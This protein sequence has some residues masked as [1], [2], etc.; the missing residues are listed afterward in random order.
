[1]DFTNDEKKLIDKESSEMVARAPRI[2]VKTFKFQGH[3][4][5]MYWGFDLLDFHDIKTVSQNRGYKYIMILLDFYS[6]YVFSVP[7]KSKD[8]P[9]IIKA[10]DNVF[11]N[12]V[13]SEF[14]TPR[15]PTFLCS[16]EESAIMSGDFKSF[17]KSMEFSVYN[18]YGK[19]GVAPV[20]S[21]IRTFKEKLSFFW[22]RQRR[23]WIDH[24][25]E[26]VSNYNL[27]KHSALITKDGEKVSPHEVYIDGVPLKKEA[28][29]Y[30]EN[31]KTKYDLDIGDRVRFRV[32]KD[33]S[34]VKKKSLLPN[35]SI[36]VY[37][38]TDIIKTSKNQGRN[39]RPN[40]GY[41]IKS[42]SENYKLVD[43]FD[44]TFGQELRNANKRLFYRNELKKSRLDDN[45]ISKLSN[46]SKRL[47]RNINNPH[48]I[49]DPL[50]DLSRREQRVAK[51]I[52][53]EATQQGLDRYF[54]KKVSKN[55]LANAFTRHGED[56]DSD[57]EPSE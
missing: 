37:K 30:P 28:E 29:A 25:K 42:L 51:A 34:S 15:I 17:A 27:S 32:N 49:T 40:I 43:K 13:D 20:E 56:S 33:L 12:N 9:E 7:L 54:G 23:N 36:D 5:D 35:Y 55:N 11:K 52:N 10:F 57:Y 8:T 50:S 46:M 3:A 48:L 45:E 38:V 14:G 24:Y 39:T 4:P 21:F 41:R 6:R 18:A 44:P 1:M 22:T 2:P 31:P 26:I 16:D 19:N 53:R 47:V